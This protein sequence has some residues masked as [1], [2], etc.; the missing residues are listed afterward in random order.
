MAL[1]YLC[2]GQAHLT[3]MAHLRESDSPSSPLQPYSVPGVHPPL[4]DQVLCP[5]CHLT[6]LHAYVHYANVALL[7]PAEH[8]SQNQA[9]L[10]ATVHES[11]VA[12]LHPSS[13]P[14]YKECHHARPLRGLM[15]AL[16]AFQVAND[17][18]VLDQVK[19]TIHG[20]A[21]SPLCFLQL[22]HSRSQSRGFELT[23]RHFPLHPPRI[24]T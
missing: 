24:D 10:T 1:Q 5:V 3:N 19:N 23:K 15:C 2:D 20:Y 6:D 7:L 13:Q 16:Y 4:A 17:L 21:A 8:S 9:S 11:A 12:H 22:H 18:H 14:P